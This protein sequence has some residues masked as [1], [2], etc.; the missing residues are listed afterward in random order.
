MVRNYVF[1]WFKKWREIINIDGNKM[2]KHISFYDNYEPR[3]FRIYI[4]V[5][6]WNTHIYI[7]PIYIGKWSGHRAVEKE[8][9]FIV[10]SNLIYILHKKLCRLMEII[11]FDVYVRLYAHL[12]KYAAKD[13]VAL[14]FPS[15]SRVENESGL[16]K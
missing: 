13:G 3:D 8:D 10:I 15:T 2:L 6:S 12:H 4:N 14:T 16:F 5:G 11:S 7:E 9:V 1:F